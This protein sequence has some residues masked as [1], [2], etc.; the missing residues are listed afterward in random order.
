MHCLLGNLF[1]MWYNKPRCTIRALFGLPLMRFSVKIVMTAISDGLSK[2]LWYTA[3]HHPQIPHLRGHMDKNEQLTAQ[4]K[5]RLK[6]K[7]L[8]GIYLLYG[9]EEFIVSYY[10][11]RFYSTALEICGEFNCSRMREGITAHQIASE[12]SSPAMMGELKYCEL[13]GEVLMALKGSSKTIAAQALADLAQDCEGLCC[14]IHFSPAFKMSAAAKKDEILSEL[15]ASPA[16]I[17]VEFAHLTEGNLI[18]WIGQI[19]R[20]KKCTITADA[21]KLLAGYVAG[22]MYSVSNELEKLCHLSADRGGEITAELVR[23]AV[24][25]TP[26]LQAFELSN[27]IIDGN[28][29]AVLEAVEKS[30]Y[31]REETTTIISAFAGAYNGMLSV[32]Q[33]YS[34]GTSAEAIAKQTGLHPYRVKI[35]LTAGNK[36]GIAFIKQALLILSEADVRTKSSRIDAYVAVEQIVAR[37]KVAAAATVKS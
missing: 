30:K 18:K 6:T 17:A 36:L 1:Q 35:Y 16:V 15:L 25:Q 10:R 24:A 23:S 9:E 37:L 32:L 13:D 21:A 34:T 4:I 12:L 14:V 20:Q 26:Q 11:D 22:D 19:A 3:Y 8:A 27:A 29:A 5:E 2:R 33:L 28:Y 7:Q 31:H